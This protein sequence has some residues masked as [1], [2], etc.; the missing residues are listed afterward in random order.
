MEP[1][2]CSLLLAVQENTIE[3]IEWARTAGGNDPRFRN[4]VREL[5]AAVERLDEWTRE[6]EH[7]RG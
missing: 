4:A 3:T 7:G 5:R 6:G 1:G 2:I